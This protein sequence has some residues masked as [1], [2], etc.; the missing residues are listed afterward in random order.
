MDVVE[1]YIETMNYE[2]NDMSI[3]LQQKVEKCKREEKKSL[4]I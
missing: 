4:V 3:I 2:T 1:F